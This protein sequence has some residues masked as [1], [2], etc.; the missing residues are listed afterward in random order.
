VTAMTVTTEDVDLGVRTSERSLTRNRFLRYL[1][2]VTV[3]VVA[4]D[5]IAATP[6]EAAPGCC[7]G[8]AC[9]HCWS[10]G[11]PGTYCDTW[12][13]GCGATDYGW[14]VCCNHQWNFCHDYTWRATGQH[15]VCIVY[16]GYPCPC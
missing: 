10:N 2:V 15:C 16:C 4:R 3:G 8:G 1:S 12:Y 13:S 9:P 11:C 7:S 14:N 6:A 5:I